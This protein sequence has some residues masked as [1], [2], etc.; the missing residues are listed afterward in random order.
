MAYFEIKG[1]EYELKLTYKSVKR[2]NKAFEGGS[3][4]LIGRAVQGDLDALP[5]ILHA[6]LLHTDENFTKADVEQAI[7]QA[8]EQEKLSFD[9]II[10]LTNEVV[11]DSFF[12]RPTVEKLTKNN[13]EMKKALEQLLD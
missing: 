1:K 13:P 8:I 5:I 2:L 6:G 12:Y 10:K 11:T 3:F 7:E 4:E 9:G